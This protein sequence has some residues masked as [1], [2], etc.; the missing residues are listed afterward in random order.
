MLELDVPQPRA[1]PPQPDRV[2]AP[3]R[4]AERFFERLRRALVDRRQRQAHDADDVAHDP[5]AAEGALHSGR[6]GR[7]LAG[8]ELGLERRHLTGVVRDDRH[9]IPAHSVG[10]VPFPHHAGDA[11]ELFVRRGREERR[12][13]G[14]DLVGRHRNRRATVLDATRRADRLGHRAGESGE[15]GALPVRA[16]E[17]MHLAE[18][19]GEPREQF[20]ARPPES[21]RGDV[22]VAE[23]QDRDAAIPQSRHDSHT[24]AGELL[25]IIDQHRTQ[26][27][28]RAEGRRL[29]RAQDRARLAQQ[30]GGVAVRRTERVED[31]AVLDEELRGR[32]PRLIARVPELVRSSADLGAFGEERPQLRAEALRGT[33]RIAERVRPRDAPIFGVAREQLGDD[34]VLIC[35]RE[36][37]RRLVPLS[38]HRPP[39]HLERERA[40][41][42]RQRPRCRLADPHTDPVAQSRRGLTVRRQRQHLLRTQPLDV[43]QLHDTVDEGAGLPRPRGADDHAGCGGLCGDHGTLRGIRCHALHAIRMDGHH[44]PH[45]RSVLRYPDAL[46]LCA[47]GETGAG[48]RSRLRHAR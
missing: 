7:Y 41:R 14:V 11:I 30:I 13:S 29:R 19:T 48:R 16:V 46:P 34:A 6:A 28:E 38:H 15:R 23:G 12:D 45:E 21:A 39:D 26:R 44:R 42:S 24:A 43:E 22:G 33:H 17:D 5:L 18:H 40:E 32:G 2:H 10:E 37:R 8:G 9:P 36:Q 27:R 4:R 25:R 47:H 3:E 35:S 31:G 20:G 1:Q